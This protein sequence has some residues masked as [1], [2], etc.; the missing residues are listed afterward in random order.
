[1]VRKLRAGTMPPIGR[2]RPEKP[3][4]ASLVS[5]LESGL[6]RAAAAKPNPGRAPLHRLNR[7]EYANAIRDLLALDIDVRALLPA[8]DTDEHG[9]DNVAE[10]LTVSPAL[11][12]RYL[13]AARKIGRTALGYPTGPG[14]ELYQLPRMLTQ[15]DRLSDD[16]PFGSRGGAAVRHYFPADGE[17]TIKVQLKSNLYDY[18]I[19]LGR[20]HQLDVRLDGAL[21][22]RFTVGGREDINPPPLSFSGAMREHRVR[23]LR[24]RRR[25]GPRSDGPRQGR[26]AH[27]RR[28]LHAADRGKPEGVLQ[29]LQTG[30]P[31]AVNE[32]FDG[33]AASTASRS[34]A[35][36]RSG[37]A[38]RQAAARF[39]CAAPTAATR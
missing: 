36:T 24:A 9:F 29:P 7:T 5:S 35:R 21:V 38:T 14:V 11:M 31:L 32:Q 20:P 37:P 8:D 27:G 1:M 30:Y 25:R 28:V 33:H 17:Y 16:L 39:S 15:D 6:D 2:P 22:K 18:I 34:V 10:V 12:E 23:D 3:A 19:G 26:L 4:V 13:F